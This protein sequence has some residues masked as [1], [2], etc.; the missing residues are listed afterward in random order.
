MRLF[1]CIYFY[2]SDDANTDSAFK[3]CAPITKC[4][5]HINDEHIDSAENTD[6]TMP[7]QNLIEYSDN[8]SDTSRNLWQFKRHIKRACNKYWKS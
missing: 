3:N 8:Y 6:I 4:I 7:L 2:S 1:R 5:T